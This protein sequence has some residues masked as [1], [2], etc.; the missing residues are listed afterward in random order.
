MKNVELITARVKTDFHTPIFTIWQME[1]Y[2][3][4]NNFILRTD[5]WKCL[6]PMRLK[7]TPQKLYQ[8]VIHKI[9]AA[10]TLSRYCIVT[11]SNAVS[12]LIKANLCENTNIPFSKN[13]GKL[14]KINARF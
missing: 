6:F 4:R 9:V 13:Y 5:F 3:E 7:S 8:K 2:K 14:G 10:N 11:Y 12:F 1:D